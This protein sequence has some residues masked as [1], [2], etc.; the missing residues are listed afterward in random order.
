MSAEVWA[1]LWPVLNLAGLGIFTSLSITGFM[2]LAGLGDTPNLRSNHERVTPTAGGLGFVAAFGV[3]GIALSLVHPTF[4]PFFPV[5]F[6]QILSLVF[7]MGLLGL[8][9][10]IFHLSAKLK[11]GIMIILAGVGAL[12]VGLPVVFP[13]DGTAIA[14]PG[15]LS[16]LG[17]LLWIFVVVNAVNFMDGANGLITNMLMIASFVLG[18]IG[19]SEGS[20]LAA[21]LCG[22]LIAGFLGFLPYNQKRKASIFLGDSGSLVAGFVF[23]LASLSVVNVST[24]G[25]LLLLGPLLIL[26]LLADVLLTLASRAKRRQNLLSA[27]RDHIYQRLILRG[28]SHLQV[29]WIYSILALVFANVSVFAV[30]SGRIASP[31]FFILNVVIVSV[32]YGIASRVLPRSS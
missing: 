8:C 31:A 19:L 17:A 7:A 24:D 27:H 4:L 15:G 25:A 9:D 13:L 6:P 2:V 18:V 30:Q 3:C 23:A 10:D 20:V 28:F 29:A 14:L 11:F 26:P 12:S 32:L 5:N 16:F 22:V 1:H 21:F